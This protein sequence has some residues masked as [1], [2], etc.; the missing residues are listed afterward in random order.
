MH[1]GALERPVE[2]ENVDLLKKG[3]GKGTFEGICKYCLRKG[4]KAREMGQ[5]VCRQLLADRKKGLDITFPKKGL[6]DPKPK[7]NQRKERERPEG[8]PT[9]KKMKMGE[10]I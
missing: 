6:P 7:L 10:M 4:H 3:V 8:Q 9:S 1:V 5:Y 2:D